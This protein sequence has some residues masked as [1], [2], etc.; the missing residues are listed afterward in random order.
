[1]AIDLTKLERVRKISFAASVLSYDRNFRLIIVLS[2]PKALLTAESSVTDRQKSKGHIPPI[3]V[4]KKLQK[5]QGQITQTTE[6]E[7]GGN[8]PAWSPDGRWIAFT[9]DRRGDQE[10]YFMRPDGS[11]IRQ[12]SHSD[13]D[14]RVASWSPDGQQLVFVSN[15]DGN[16]EIYRMERDGTEQ[17]RLTMNDHRD[18]A[19]YWTAPGTTQAQE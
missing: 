19:P 3:N 15:R 17:V 12:L 4:C 9:S 6:G 7:A 13:H 5:I 11:E 2:L 10:V 18:F 8:S 16:W 1:M 14:D